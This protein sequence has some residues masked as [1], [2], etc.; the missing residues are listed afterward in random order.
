MK[1]CLLLLYLL[2]T[3]V[4]GWAHDFEADGIYYK[5]TSPNDLTVSVTYRD[6]SYYS[7]SDRYTG[8]VT[9]PESVT[10]NRKTYSVTSIGVYAFDTCKKLTSVTIP[11]SVTS[12]DDWAFF[13]CTGLTS[14]TIP[15]SVV[16]IGYYALGSCSGLT[17]VTIGNGVT[18]ISMKAFDDCSALTSI[19]IPNSVTSIGVYAFSGCI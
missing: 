6:N 19:D 5:I 16:T 12:I 11:E 17:S 14:V 10:Y 15:N 8:S 2:L 7:Y 9:I 18:S 13:G 1:K 3:S 4:S